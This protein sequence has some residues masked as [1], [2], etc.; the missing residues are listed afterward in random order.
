VA[1]VVADVVTGAQA[2]GIPRS[3]II[4]E[5]LNP[6]VAVVPDMLLSPEPVGAVPYAP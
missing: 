3:A 2:A 4:C 5:E 1:A 6:V